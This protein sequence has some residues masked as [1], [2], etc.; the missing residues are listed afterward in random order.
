[1][2]LSDKERE[3]LEGYFRNELTEVQKIAFE[4]IKVKEAVQLELE[5]LKNMELAF[6]HLERR[7]LKKQF[8]RV[9]K[10]LTETKKLPVYTTVWF[11]AAIFLVIPALSLW[12]Y[13]NA[14]YSNANLA[15]TYYT[16]P[17][18]DVE[19]SQG[20]IDKA[21]TAAYEAYM[22]KEYEKVLTIES[23][24]VEMMFLKAHACYALQQY[25]KALSI[26][27]SIL[28]QKQHDEAEWLKIN[29]LLKQEKV[30]EAK[31]MLV[32]VSSNAKH[33]Y[34]QQ[35]KRLLNDLNHPLRKLIF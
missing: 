28:S 32:S 23:N 3:L 10:Q 17:V 18:Y 5:N 33:I 29:V 6:A 14:T 8:Q 1:M 2:S 22:N 34:Q 7:R 27:G 25:D 20:V 35:A 16:I 24:S 19:R 31:A 4:E 11:K 13:V 30:A 21:Y 12:L 26:L 9:E 15:Q